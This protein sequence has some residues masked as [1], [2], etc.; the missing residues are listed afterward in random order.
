MTKRVTAASHLSTVNMLAVDSS[1]F[2]PK[3]I[4]N[5]RGRGNAMLRSYVDYLE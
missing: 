3:Y 1:D 2:A 5:R 4:E